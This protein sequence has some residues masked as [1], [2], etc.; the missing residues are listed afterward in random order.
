M[1]VEARGES[2]VLP[3]VLDAMGGDR[4]PAV[5]VEAAIAA[6][7]AGLGPVILTG[8]AERITAEF[9][10]H[11]GLSLEQLPI[12]IQHASEVIGMAEHPSRAARTK[13]DSSMHVGLNLVRDGAAQAFVSA[14]NSGAVMAT[15]VLTLGRIARCDRPALASIMPTGGKSPTIAVDVGANVDCRATHLVQF[16]LLGAAYAELALERT[17]PKVALLSNGTEPTK[18]T[19]T[20]REAHRL[21][22]QTDLRYVGFV[23]GSA[24]PL[25]EADVLVSDGFVGNVALKVSEGVAMGLVRRLQSELEGDLL[26]SL[27][28]RLMKRAFQ[29]LNDV[30]DWRKMGGAPLLG[31]NGIVTVAHG[32]S[33]AAALVEAIRLARKLYASD[34]IE[35]LTRALEEAN[36][37]LE[38]QTSTS[39]LPIS[40]SGSFEHS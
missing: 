25:G 3:V 27:G 39:E 2:P 40:R 6:C 7:D 13:K 11:S 37:P 9:E 24:L 10:H 34:L 18:G 8:D 23:E 19:E 22:T 21:L 15:A 33:N 35:R 12:E 1:T 20:L 32:A 38:M 17:R 29:R 5:T 36:A 14:G 4:A 28:A 30:L 31:V 26:G 16:A